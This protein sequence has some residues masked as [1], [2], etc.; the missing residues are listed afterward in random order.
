[1]LIF[2]SCNSLPEIYCKNQI[3]PKTGEYCFES[4]VKTQCKL[5]VPKGSNEA[6]QKAWS[7]ENIIEE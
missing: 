7:F 3:P 5:Y 6:Y 4:I 2:I 1:M